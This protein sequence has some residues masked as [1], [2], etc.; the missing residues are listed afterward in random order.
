MDASLGRLEQRALGILCAQLAVARQRDFVGGEMV[1]SCVPWRVG[2]DE[3][4]RGVNVG[5]RPI[6][7]VLSRPAR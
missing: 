6:R 3:V 5:Q 1:R 4:L 2:V 7:V